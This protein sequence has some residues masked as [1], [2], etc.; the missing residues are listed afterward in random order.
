MSKCIN[1][2]L[3]EFKRIKKSEKVFFENNHDKLKLVFKILI[4]SLDQSVYWI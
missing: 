1:L 2:I 3:A 4:A